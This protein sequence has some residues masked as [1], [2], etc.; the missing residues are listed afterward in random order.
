MYPTARPEGGFAGRRMQIP[1]PIDW[2]FFRGNVRPV[3]AEVVE[4]WH[5][6]LAPSDHQ[7]VFATYQFS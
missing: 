2:Q 4:Y 3:S 7:P 6:G 1:K 5:D